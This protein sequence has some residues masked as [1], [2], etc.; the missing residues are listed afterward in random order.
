LRT[1]Q[2]KKE[3]F[4][5]P[6]SPRWLPPLFRSGWKLSRKI[7]RTI[8]EVLAASQVENLNSVEGFLTYREGA[9][10]FYFAYTQSHP[11]RV[12]EIGS[13][14]GKSTVWLA[15]ALELSQ[16]DE[17]VVAIDPHINTG[18]TGVVP[19][20]DEQSS[21]DAFIENLSRLNLSRSVQPIVAV[22]ETVAKNW[23]EQI[24]F[25]F[26]DGSHR[27]EDV[28]LDLVL[29]EPWVSIGGVICLHDTK[30]NGPFVGV[31]RAMNEYLGTS[32]RFSKTLELKNMTVFIKL[33]SA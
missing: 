28:K 1:E 12:V 19:V 20:Y 8:S 5:K 7:N 25:L 16:R 15:K 10:L 24:R 2:I 13:F 29:W 4:V 31:R 11:G 27:Y 18:E 21:Y 6:H 14:K 22:S 26:I 23:N 32:K 9:L 17:K 33:A 30:F 3:L